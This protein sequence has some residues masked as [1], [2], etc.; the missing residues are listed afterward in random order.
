MIGLNRREVLGGIAGTGLGLM[1]RQARAGSP[2]LRVALLAPLSGP[3]AQQGHLMLLGAKMAVD[4][5]NAKGGIKSLGGAKMQ[6]ITA[7]AGESTETAVSAA[8]KLVSDNPDLGGG[9]GAWLSSFT[10]AITEVTERAHLP[11]L[12]ISAADAITSRGFKY[13]FQTTYRGSLQSAAVVPA[14]I[15]LGEVAGKAPKTVGIITDN[16]ASP[17]AFA[18][19]MR[20]GGLAKLGLKVVLDMTYTPPLADATPLVERVRRARPDFLFFVPT[21]VSDDKLFFEKMQEFHLGEGRIPIV[22]QGSS[23]TDPELPKSIDPK[24]LEGVMVIVMDWPG[25]DHVELSE[26]FKKTTGQP[27]MG[28]DSLVT[29]GD[30]W[31]LKHAAEMAKSTDREAIATAIR[32]MDLSGGIASYYAG[33]HLQFDATGNRKGAGIMLAQW[34]QG[35]PVAVYPTD[36]AVAKPIWAKKS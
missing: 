1:T 21:A 2:E 15:K 28:Q 22:S 24:L 9:T 8:K 33:N 12:T 18:K 7:D 3:W 36:N 16:T 4:D 30:M 26:R 20:E 27:W 5:I 31:V 25:K 29:Y 14:L 32:Q 17:M 11:W 23:L 35:V 19:P 13:V 10:I 6:L 34:Q